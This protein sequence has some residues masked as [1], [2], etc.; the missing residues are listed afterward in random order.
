MTTSEAAQTEPRLEIVGPHSPSLIEKAKGL[1]IEY[2]DSLD[3]SLCFQ[4]FEE[5][6]SGLPGVYSLP[7]GRLIIAYVG[8]EAVGC[9]AM[10]E[11]DDETCEMKRLYVRPGHRAKGIGRDLASRIIHEA[12]ETGYARMRLDTVSSMKE[13]IS[14]YRSLGFKE[15]AQYRPNPI[16]GALFMELSLKIQSKPDPV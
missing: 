1:F 3:F 12:R 2:A 7:S 14:L 10:R 16:A 5:E 9:V 4:D 13:A 6:V 15:I 8:E 11:I